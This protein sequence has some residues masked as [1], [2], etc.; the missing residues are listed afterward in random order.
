MNGSGRLLHAGVLFWPKMRLSPLQDEGVA[1]KN[2]G[3][4]IE[5]TTSVASLMHCKVLTSC[6]SSR[7]YDSRIGKCREFSAFA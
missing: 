4:V 3:V 5:V 6:A 1:L 7:R 2:R